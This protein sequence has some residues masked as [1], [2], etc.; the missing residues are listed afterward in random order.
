MPQDS[1]TLEIRIILSD[2]SMTAQVQPQGVNP[3]GTA[4]DAA[5]ADAGAPAGAPETAVGLSDASAGGDTPVDV[6][7]PAL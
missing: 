1:R 6:G 7:P 2:S 5:A 3:R 4:T